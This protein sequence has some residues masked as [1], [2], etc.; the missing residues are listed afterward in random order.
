MFRHFVIW[1]SVLSGSLGGCAMQTGKLGPAN[2]DYWRLLENDQ[3]AD[4][5]FNYLNAHVLLEGSDEEKQRVREKALAVI[6]PFMKSGNPAAQMWYGEISL[7][8]GMKKVSNL[9]TYQRNMLRSANSGYLPATRTVARVSRIG[10]F[11][12]KDLEMAVQLIKDNAKYGHAQDIAVLA[13]LYKTGKGVKKDTNEYFKLQTKAALT[14]GG[15]QRNALAQAYMLGTGG[16]KNLPLAF[17]WYEVGK[18]DNFSNAISAIFRNA[19]IIL[20]KLSAD[21]KNVA[22][23]LLTE[24]R[25][26]VNEFYENIVSEAEKGDLFYQRILGRKYLSGEGVKQDFAEAA[27]YLVLAVSNES[28]KQRLYD[29]I[30]VILAVSKLSD[31]QRKK[32]DSFLSTVKNRSVVI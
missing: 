7:L 1:F 23:G 29:L 20:E 5:Y 32:F 14:G 24:K 25:S 6:K 2:I 12:P 18:G 31:G 4:A 22:K 28:N 9:L 13:A 15:R 10:M 26:E 8:L 3:F 19:S 17:A 27:K 16:T 30:G 11:L 21:E